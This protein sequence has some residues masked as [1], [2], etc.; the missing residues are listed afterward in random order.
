MKET[1][2]VLGGTTRV[3]RVD[4]RNNKKYAFVPHG[5]VA[6][7]T[8]KKKEFEESSIDISDHQI[9]SNVCL[10]TYFLDKNYVRDDFS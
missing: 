6:R 10:S 5:T 7:K 4:L 8:K 1:K 2:Y 3:F 9:S